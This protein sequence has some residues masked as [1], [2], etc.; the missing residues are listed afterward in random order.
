[1]KK[2][3]NKNRN[4]NNHANKTPKTK[5]PPYEILCEEYQ[6]KRIGAVDFVTQ[7]SDEMTAEYEQFC[8]DKRLDKNKESSA[9]GFMDY[10]EKLFE[11]SL[12]N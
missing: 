8:R 12:E 10:R 6:E 5:Y 1:M 2:Y 9:L 11:E 4:R 7:Q 3:K